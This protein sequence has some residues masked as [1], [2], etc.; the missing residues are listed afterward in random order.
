MLNFVEIFAITSANLPL[1]SGISKEFRREQN[2]VVF[3]K[4]NT[5]C[6]SF[7]WYLT[8][9]ETYR[10][11]KILRFC[12]GIR[13]LDHSITFKEL[14]QTGEIYAMIVSIWHNVIFD[15]DNLLEG[16]INAKQ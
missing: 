11:R 12:R 16:I 15:N 8:E 4:Q 10:C 9:V 2:I 14:E 7:T 13:K 1:F 3:T 6:I 5:F